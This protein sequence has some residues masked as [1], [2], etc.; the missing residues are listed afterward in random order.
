M[1][2]IFY[3]DCEATSP[4]GKFRLEARSPHNGMINHQDGRTPSEDEY[5]FKY[6]DYQRDFRYQLVDTTSTSLASQLFGKK[7]GHVVWERWQERREDSP[8]ELI[9]SD[10]GW[11]ILRT[12]GF[13]PELIAVS[14]EGRDVVRV[15][16]RGPKTEDA[17][18]E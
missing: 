12:H 11:S 3:P 2:A 15:R 10:E 1:T 6:R 17:P 7:G 8:H 14:P 9:V 13:N 4:N 16:I 18:E 5:A